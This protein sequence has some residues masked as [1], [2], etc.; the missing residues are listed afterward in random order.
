MNLRHLVKADKRMN[1]KLNICTFLIAIVCSINGSAQFLF[2]PDNSEYEWTIVYVDTKT[3][4]NIRVSDPRPI[5]N[6]LDAQVME[7]YVYNGKIVTDNIFEDGTRTDTRKYPLNCYP[8]YVQTRNNS[9]QYGSSL[10][11]SIIIDRSGRVSK[12]YSANTVD[13]NGYI[14][15]ANKWETNVKYLSDTLALIYSKNAYTNKQSFEALFLDSMSNLMFVI[16]PDPGIDNAIL[17]SVINGKKNVV[18]L[19]YYCA[20]RFKYNSK[21]ELINIA[22]VCFKEGKE[23]ALRTQYFIYQNGRPVSSYVIDE[24][25]KEK[26]MIQKY[27]YKPVNNILK[28]SQDG[29]RNKANGVHDASH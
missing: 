8:Q 22:M 10:Y 16:W 12:V 27:T 18:D 15:P 25:T 6:K 23:Y 13:K 17:D 21:K 7:Y 1:M 14:H 3:R 2:N 20:S 4:V 26:I 28:I 24:K 9:F 11:D 5:K 29:K 19:Q